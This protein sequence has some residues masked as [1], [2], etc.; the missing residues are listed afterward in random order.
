M[1]RGNGSTLHAATRHVSAKGLDS[2]HFFTSHTTSN[3][4]RIIRRATLTYLPY[5]QECIMMNP[6][7]SS[8]TFS[9][10]T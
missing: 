9:D 8:S 7:R 1:R 4:D 2:G 10:S 6:F 5:I 3:Q